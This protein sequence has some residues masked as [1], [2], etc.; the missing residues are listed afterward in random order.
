MLK[1]ALATIVV[2][3]ALLSAYAYSWTHGVW[4]GS[5][6]TIQTLTAGSGYVFGSYSKCYASQAYGVLVAN[7][8][9]SHQPS[10]LNGQ[11]PN[12]GWFSDYSTTGSA[13]AGCPSPTRTSGLTGPTAVAAIGDAI[14]EGIDLTAGNIVMIGCGV[15]DRN[16]I[17]SVVVWLEGNTVTLSASDQMIDP[18]THASVWEVKLSAGTGQ[19]GPMTVGADCIP[20]VTTEGDRVVTKT[21]MVNTNASGAGYINRSLSSLNYYADAYAG[22]AS[23]TNCDG[24][25]PA[26]TA[27]GTHCPWQ[28]VLFHMGVNAATYAG[29]VS[30][31]TAS[32]CYMPDNSGAVL[33]LASHGTVTATIAQIG[34]TNTSTMTVT[35]LLS[36][37]VS[38]GDFITGP[39]IPIAALLL[40]GGTCTSGAVVPTCTFIVNEGFTVAS[41]ITV[42][43]AGTYVETLLQDNGFSQYNVS[44]ETIPFKVTT[45]TQYGATIKANFWT[46]HYQGYYW[47]NPVDMV[48]YDNVVFDKT[49][50]GSFYIR[51]AN[52][53]Y[54]R[55]MWISR[56]GIWDE[57]GPF[58]S[59]VTF[60]LGYT[61]LGQPDSNVDITESTFSTTFTDYIKLYRGDAGYYD[62]INVAQQSSDSSN[63][64]IFGYISIGASTMWTNYFP[65]KSNSS[66][67][68]DSY[69]Q[70]VI[71]GVAFVTD[72]SYCPY[73]SIPTGCLELTF[74]N[75]TGA[76]ANIAAGAG[77]YPGGN[78][79]YEVC[80]LTGP[81]Y[82]GGRQPLV[83]RWPSSVAPFGA[84]AGCVPMNSFHDLGTSWKA[85]IQAPHLLTSYGLVAVNCAPASGSFSGNGQSLTPG[86][87][88]PVVTNIAILGHTRHSDMAE[89]SNL[90]HADD[91]GPDNLFAENWINVAGDQ[92]M[93]LQ[94]CGACQDAG[95]NLITTTT[96][97]DVTSFSVA[98]QTAVT[99]A[100]TT[101]SAVL[102]FASSPTVK[103]GMGVN[104]Q[105]TPAN[106]PS[107]TTVVSSTG[108]T[109]TLNSAV[110]VPSGDTIQVTG[111]APLPGDFIMITTGSL[112]GE[113]EPV[114]SVSGK[115]AGTLLAQFPALNTTIVSA[116][117]GTPVTGFVS[118]RTAIPTTLAGS[119]TYNLVLT[120]KMD[121]SAIITAATLC[122]GASIP[123]CAGAPVNF[124]FGGATSC[125]PCNNNGGLVASDPLSFTTT[126]ANPTLVVTVSG[127]TGDSVY[128]GS[129][130][131]WNAW[132]YTTDKT[133]VQSPGCSTGC[134]AQAGYDLGVETLAYTNPPADISNQTWID[135]KSASHV[136]IGD[137]SFVTN[138]LTSGASL[139]T[140]GKFDWTYV[141]T[142]WGG[143]NSGSYHCENNITVS[144]YTCASWLN[145]F[146]SIWEGIKFD[147]G[148]A[149]NWN[150]DTNTF[151]RQPPVGTN[152]VFSSCPIN[153]TNPTLADYT[154][155]S[156]HPTGGCVTQH[157]AGNPATGKSILKGDWIGTAITNLATA[158]VGAQQ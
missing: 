115:T 58:C 55:A 131:G 70:P 8:A 91:F 16:A 101:S 7:S 142:T 107:N 72:A 146:D 132:F 41:P 54:A 14:Y 74:D 157:P 133:A 151:E 1:R 106:I 104:D 156:L 89:W 33:N 25:R 84:E 37:Q 123:D 46:A 63:Q 80:F 26:S 105:T 15:Q 69:Y 124:T 6:P 73:G 117:P 122:V 36:G 158:I 127:S 86:T 81:Q 129:V 85:Y 152:F 96:S 90:Q 10:A 103:A 23:D 38:A 82:N 141:Q 9:T 19:N 21:V 130:S 134:T 120:R 149:T 92:V 113:A 32:S 150:M 57:Y 77:N 27:S 35:G 67:N 56:S 95:G 61:D 135:I 83:N 93:L 75:T 102:H 64:A 118:N 126:G 22:V 153:F 11:I 45:A 17:G 62:S 94:S 3:L 108:T 97:G 98:Q 145:S 99:N 42:T 65:W 47:N 144:T 59:S 110:T 128:R 12:N 4:S 43:A 121:S 112:N 88:C 29:F 140:S 87:N 44:H 109:V 40:S 71:T 143:T 24:T 49:T 30:G 28:T 50:L 34:S 52:S 51:T 5:A 2:S 100:P 116:T 154:A 13:T 39:G 76:N 48:Q 139:D 20:T 138:I 78:T 147:N 60:C 68:P 136:F 125:N 18:A 114:T 53:A 111:Q 79:A 155:V 31:C 119:T 66:S 137:S 148:V